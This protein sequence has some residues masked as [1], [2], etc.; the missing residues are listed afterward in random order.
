ML[1]LLL[2]IL[3]PFLILILLV[4]LLI[5]CGNVRVGNRWKRCTPQLA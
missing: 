2:L 5:F 1:F 3:I 4:I